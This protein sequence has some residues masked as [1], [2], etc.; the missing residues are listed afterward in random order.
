MAAA[1]LVLF[2]IVRRFVHRLATPIPIQPLEPLAEVSTTMFDG[3][4]S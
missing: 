2:F 4:R 1:D 3:F